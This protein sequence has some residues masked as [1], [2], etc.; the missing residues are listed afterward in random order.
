[1]QKAKKIGANALINI[2]YF[3]TTG[4]EAG[5]GR[6]T[7]YYTIHNFRG[8]IVNIA[9]KS[10]YGRFEIKDFK[11]INDEASKLKIELLE[12]TKSSENFKAIFWGIIVLV[13]IF[14]WA[15]QNKE[16]SIPIVGTFILLFIG[17]MFAKSNNYDDW[18]NKIN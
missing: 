8:Q 10:T 13:I 5:T 4:S 18:L 9:K 15:S 17:S 14:L 3:K 12:K 7:H 11:N 6:G 16:I 2:Q 1:M